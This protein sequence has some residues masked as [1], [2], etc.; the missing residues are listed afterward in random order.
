MPGKFAFVKQRKNLTDRNSERGGSL[1]SPAIWTPI[2][3]ESVRIEGTEVIGRWQQALRT[4][5][6]LRNRLLVEDFVNWPDDPHEIVRFT[7]AYG[8]LLQ[9][10]EEGR[11]FRFSMDEWRHAQK[12]LQKMWESRAGR[13]SLTTNVPG[14][15]YRIVVHNRTLAFLANSLEGF[16]V[17]DLVMA[18]A[19]R[20]RK[21]QRPGCPNPY[22]VARHLKQHYCSPLCAEWA[23]ARWKKQW[24]EKKGSEWLGKRRKRRGKGSPK[25]PTRRA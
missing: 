13:A 9:E 1:A 21:C 23:Q 8:P 17:M 25:A 14:G 22:F 7:T 16:L 20:L 15:P 12:M 4:F 3:T 2:G 24:W 6:G 10:A 19:N 5:K 11:E 18:P